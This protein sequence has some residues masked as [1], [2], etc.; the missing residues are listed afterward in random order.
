[1][2]EVSTRNNRAKT[3]MQISGICEEEAREILQKI[4]TRSDV[5]EALRVAHLIASGIS[6]DTVSGNNY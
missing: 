3:Y 5:P 6:R 4:S 1:M 2:F